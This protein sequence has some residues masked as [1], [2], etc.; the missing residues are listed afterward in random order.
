MTVTTESRKGLAATHEVLNQVPPLVD[1][2]IFSADPTLVAAVHRYGASW[3]HDRLVSFGARLGSAEVLEW[4][5]QANRFPPQIKT[6]DR[7]GHRIDEVEFHPAYHKLMALSCEY[8]VHN[9]PWANP[10]PGAHVA[11]AAMMFMAYQTEAGHC[12]PISMTYSVVPALSRQ[13]DLFARWE[14][15]IAGNGY[16]GRLMPANL[17]PGVIFGMGMTEKQGGSDVRANSTVAEPVG[18]G[19]P[20]RITAA[21]NTPGTSTEASGLSRASA[22]SGCSHSGRVRAQVGP[23]SANMRGKT[24]SSQCRRRLQTQHCCANTTFTSARRRSAGS[25]AKDGHRGRM[26]AMKSPA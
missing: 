8:G 17:K 7:T 13:A 21:I 12:C 20:L 26:D 19:G 10:G 4:A 24:H 1:T 9:L 11:R 3:A 5:E 16:E 18:S 6:H 25:H 22:N 23:V 2:N 14:P 15:L